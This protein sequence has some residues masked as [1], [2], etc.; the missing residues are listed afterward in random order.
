MRGVKPEYRTWIEQNMPDL[1]RKL[2]PMNSS[3][4]LDEL[5]RITGL[6]IP[7]SA[8]INATFGLFIDKLKE[9]QAQQ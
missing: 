4:M 3:Q 2:G 8:E 5:N 1:D 6:D 9:M 7:G